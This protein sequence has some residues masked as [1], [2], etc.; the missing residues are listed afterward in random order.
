MRQFSPICTLPET[1]PAFISAPNGRSTF[2]I[3]WTCVTVL[4]LCSWSVLHLA[5]PEQFTPKTRRQR[6]N[7]PAARQGLKVKW[8]LITLIGPEFI[9]GS[10]AAAWYSARRNTPDM[11]QVA[12][13]D[14]VPWSRVHTSFADIGGFVLRFH[15]D[16][17]FM[18]PGMPDS[19]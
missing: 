19:T 16:D 14:G 15:N 17:G 2:D 13:E 7:L 11:Q 18:A 4:I 10:A 6:F 12:E 1:G 8:M 5:V 3:V 9:F